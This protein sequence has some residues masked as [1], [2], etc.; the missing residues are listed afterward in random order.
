M[1]A[2][3]KPLPVMADYADN[4]GQDMLCNFSDKG[5]GGKVAGGLAQMLEIIAGGPDG[6]FSLTMPL[7]WSKFSRANSQ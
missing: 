4:R 3:T 7:Q 1:F 6:S 2:L 5:Y